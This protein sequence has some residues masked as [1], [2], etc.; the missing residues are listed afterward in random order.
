MDV[1]AEKQAWSPRNRDHGHDASIRR[2]Y[3]MAADPANPGLATAYVW[4][5]GQLFLLTKQALERSQPVTLNA[6][7]AAA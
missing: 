5:A 4:E 6:W 1:G 2:S 7:H 3:D